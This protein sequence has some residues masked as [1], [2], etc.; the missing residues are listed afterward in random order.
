MHEVAAL[1]MWGAACDMGVRVHLPL[2]ACG[3]RPL[4]SGAMRIHMGW[5][6]AS[7][8]CV[9]RWASSRLSAVV[10]F[11]CGISWRCSSC[12]GAFGGL[13]ASG[14]TWLGFGLGLGFGIGFE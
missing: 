9:T 10:H 7:V 13:R 8:C 4:S 6:L 11:C 2:Q 12:H 1:H 14:D 3:V 5:P